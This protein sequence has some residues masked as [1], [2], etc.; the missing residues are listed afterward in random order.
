MQEQS[1]SYSHYPEEIRHA[2]GH[3]SN[4]IFPALDP[5]VDC[6]CWPSYV[7]ALPLRLS[8]QPVVVKEEL[9]KRNQGWDWA[10]VGQE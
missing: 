8:P 2:S 6:I 3:S 4:G 1:N 10:T 9:G 5:E 7:F